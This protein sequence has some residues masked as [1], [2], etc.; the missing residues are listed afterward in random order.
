MQLLERGPIQLELSHLLHE[1][2]SG[3]GRLVF[4]GGE[5]GIGK[6]SLVQR[7]ARV[8]EARARVLVGACDPLSTPRPLGPLLDM[9][10]QLSRRY[11]DQLAHQPDKDTLFRGFLAELSGK[12]QPAVV[13]FEDV[14]WADE[15]TLDLLRFL[16][17]RLGS[18]PALLIAT[19]RSDEVGDRHPLRVVLG[20][21]ATLPAVQRL[22]LEPLSLAAVRTLCNGTA[23][24]P[25]RLHEQTDGNPFFVTEV[26]AAGGT[27]IPATVRDAVL[28]RAARLPPQAREA[29]DAAAVLGFRFEPWLLEK[30]AGPCSAA[31]DACLSGG[32]LR[33]EGDRFVF[34]HE[35]T[36]QAILEVLPPHRALIL[37]RAALAALRT[38]APGTVEPGR[39]AHHAEGAGDGEAVLEYAPLAAR[40]ARELSAHREAAAQYRRTLRF[41]D[42]LPPAQRAEL[43][44]A[45]SWECAATDHWDEA[46]RADYELIALWR[47]EGNRVREA[48]SLG[49]LARCLTVVGRT[50][51][52]EAA[53]RAGIEALEAFPP[54]SELADAFSVQALIRTMSSDYAEAR[55][56]ARR[57]V[58]VAESGGYLR[59]R[60][61]AY[62]RL[63][64]ATIASGDPDG[65]CFLRRALDLAREAGIHWDAAGAYVSLG[66]AWAEQY[67]FA[68]AETLL[69]EGIRYAEEHELEGIL[70][71]ML[72][73]QALAH[74]Y[75][76]R[77]TEAE[78]SGQLVTRRAR[79]SALT[80]VAQ[81]MTALGRLHVRR[82]DAEAGALLDEVL[83]MVSPTGLLQYLA[84]VRAARAE[85]AWLAGDPERVRQEAQAALGLALEK[86]HPWLAGELLFWLHRAGERV[87]VPEWI[88]RPFARQ[89]AGDWTGAGAEW[90]RLGCPYEAAQALME[91]GEPENL[92]AALAEFE[93]LGAAPAAQLATRRLREAGVRGI[94]RGPRASTR[95]NP[96][97]LTRRE[98][99]VVQLLAEGLQ[100]VE[101][102]KRL[103]ISP[104]TAGHHVSSI[105]AKL[106]V[107]TRTEAAREAL[108]LG[109]VQDRE[110]TMPK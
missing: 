93:R 80:R 63:G 86:R 13:I 97:Q 23:L 82:G 81:A 75:L 57:A 30:V 49:F 71:S 54:G 34:G 47:A 9:Q 38:L 59:G 53:N 68:R 76:G 6:S 7:F 101:L 18:T 43:W 48:W 79:A 40:R 2:A 56:W 78:Q 109:I 51:D 90:Q 95:T 94:P 37:H 73:W 52:A 10:E 74:L 24:D 61:L 3:R 16:G 64:W 29:L 8:V 84:P 12:E 27:G 108:R 31:I 58:E 91:S 96:G 32:M 19:Y 5:A 85:A 100:D 89:I 83:A 39:L 20:D 92:R 104:R 102:A 35:L 28:A 88:A 14:H 67:E 69:A 70:T 72:S 36:R 17:R 26:I 66:A 99:E 50:A 103:F 46:I 25:V 1:A 60:I 15:A 106:G 33:V 105:L 77:W 110:P 65:E 45:Y 44:E 87:E 4:L 22:T 21:L 62:N 11:A 42:H 98:V 107:R 41:A 55:E